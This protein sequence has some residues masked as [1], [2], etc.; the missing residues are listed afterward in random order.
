M[1]TKLIPRNQAE[2]QD[3]PKIGMPWEQYVKMDAP[4]RRVPWSYV[5]VKAGSDWTD[6]MLGINVVRPAQDYIPETVQDHTHPPRDIQTGTGQAGYVL[7]ITSAGPAWAST[8]Q[9]GVAME[10]VTGVR[11]NE[12]DKTIEVK[13]RTATVLTSS[14]DAESAWTA[15]HTG[16]TC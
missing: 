12:T 1:K 2:E 4:L 8:N 9:T 14:S 5:R 6:E 3:P 16:S 15:I 10:I 13:T 7:T 11:V